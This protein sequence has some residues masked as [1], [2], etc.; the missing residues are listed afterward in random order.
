MMLTVQGKFS[1]WK[2]DSFYEI[3]MQ[4]IVLYHFAIFHQD[5]IRFVTASGHQ[6]Q[7]FYVMNIKLEDMNIYSY[8]IDHAEYQ[9]E[10]IIW[11]SL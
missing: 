1:Y 6:I 9:Y 4:D 11:I 3:L 8:W 7:S 5:I 10:K 2:S